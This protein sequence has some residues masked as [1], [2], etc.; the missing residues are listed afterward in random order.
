MKI[1]KMDIK[2]ENGHEK[3]NGIMTIL[4]NMNAIHINIVIRN[5]MKNTTISRL[6]T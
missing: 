5:E 4:C 1:K 6:N 2:I 3:K